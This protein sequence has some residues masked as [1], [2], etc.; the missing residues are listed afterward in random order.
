MEKKAGPAGF[1]IARGEDMQDMIIY[2]RPFV[3]A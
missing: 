1:F 2:T 3:M